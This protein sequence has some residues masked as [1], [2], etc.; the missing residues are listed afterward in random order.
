MVRLERR[1]ARYCSGRRQSEASPLGE[2][3]VLAIS[4]TGRQV[5]VQ[6]TRLV[7]GTVDV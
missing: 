2:A 6:F 7:H 5:R 3:A 4:N 1:P